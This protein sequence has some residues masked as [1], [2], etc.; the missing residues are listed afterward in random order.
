[1][2][3]I[4]TKVS[5]NT[6]NSYRKKLIYILF[7]SKMHKDRENRIFCAL[8]DLKTSEITVVVEKYAI[9]RSTLRDREKGVTSRRDAQIEY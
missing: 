5:L 9:P 6:T 8:N 7:K 3:R 4:V 1:M 2:D